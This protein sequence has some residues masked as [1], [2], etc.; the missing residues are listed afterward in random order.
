MMRKIKLYIAISLDGKIAKPNGDVGWLDVVPNPDKNDYGYGEFFESI[1]TTLMGRK[2]FKQ[3]E[4]FE[5]PFPYQGLKNFVFTKHPEEHTSEEVEFVSGDIVSFVNELKSNPGK[6]IWLIG[7][8]QINA[9]L[10]NHQ[11]ID[12][13]QIFVMPVV[14]GAGIPLFHSLASEMP[15]NLVETKPYSSGVVLL[16]YVS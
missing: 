14:L 6:D 15:L 8:G 2:T 11:L 1:D 16:K 5:G 3:V 12:E 13:M 10:L 9:L 7:G 4:S